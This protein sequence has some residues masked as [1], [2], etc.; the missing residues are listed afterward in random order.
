MLPKAG[1]FLGW[2]DDFNDTSRVAAS[3]N[4]VFSG[5]D[6]RLS[7]PPSNLSRVGLMLGRGAPGDFD[8]VELAGPSV[9]FDQG[10]YRMWYFGSPGGT[11]SVGYADSPDGRVWTKRGVVVSPSLPTDAAS[12]AYSE[13]VKVGSQYR[14]Y[15]SGSDGSTY[16]IHLATS[17]DGLVWAKQGVV[18]DV[19]PPGSGEDRNVY[20]PS[21]VVRSGL[22]SMWYGGQPSSGGTVSTF[23][24][25]SSDGVSWTR[26]GMV[27]PHGLP[28]SFDEIAAYY[29]SVRIISST[30]E[31]VYSAA[32][33]GQE[34]LGLAE[35]AD[36]ISWQKKGS[37][38]DL[39]PPD[40]SPSLG[41]PFLHVESNGT[42][43]VYY[44]ARGASG[45]IFLAVRPAAPTTGWLRSQEVT[46]P[47][48]LDWAWFNQSAS[49]PS[50]T[51]LNV[52]VRDA[53]T[54]S[55]LAGLENV[56]AGVVDLRTVDST[57]YPRLVF[58][59]WLNGNSSTSPVLDSWAASWTDQRQPSFAGLEN[60]TDLGTSGAV[61]L[62]WSVAVDPS[63][64]VL[65]NVYQAHGGNPSDF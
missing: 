46:I 42:W 8:S 53:A 61:R 63:P 37:V 58:E 52:S 57:L 7:N 20:K 3:S 29:P 38:L 54:G 39:L 23:L 9:L 56:T 25:T 47:A 50:N 65:Y 59:G 36:G 10:I 31:M 2:R 26:R 4:V 24:A 30:Y 35:S 32:S 16:R 19:G 17:T 5:A 60:A 15:Y 18:L 49:V 6:V 45:Q 34:R 21:V 13:V 1:T 33:P 11:W 44:G 43:S 62:T 64:P 48:G 55:F 12:V 27:L 40:E 51:W 22:H 41:T 28:G 14:M